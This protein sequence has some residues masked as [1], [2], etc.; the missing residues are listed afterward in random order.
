MEAID[1]GWL[2]VLPPIIAIVLALISKEVI[3]SLLVGI[4]SGAFL[5]SIN[6]GGGVVKT[7]DVTFTLMAEKMGDNIN[8]LIFLGLLGALV[9]VVTKAG[10]SQAY[11]EWATRRITSPTGAKLA[12]SALGS[13]IFI[14]DYFNCL[15]VGTVMRP[16]TDKYK[17]SRAK[18]AYLID[19]TAA[20][21][22]IIAPVSSW[23][24][25]VAS[26]MEENG[27][28]NGFQAFIN[29]IPFNLYA[30]L[31]IVMIVVLALT[32]IDFGSMA[33]SEKV[34][35]MSGNAAAKPASDIDKVA[36]EGR[37]KVIDLVLPIVTL[38]VFAILSML[39][40]RIFQW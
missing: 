4:L 9:V 18:L 14:D 17:I 39:Y 32:K 20:P 34:A 22:C 30:I 37:G 1:I 21:I 40:V 3:S 2:S 16:V 12:T 7:V 31:T 26:Q 24:A 33:K 36:V 5:Y 11:G 28:A 19:A 13:L 27:L 10:G 23:A 35:Q 6:T 29:T 25:A 15:T 38:I 8:I